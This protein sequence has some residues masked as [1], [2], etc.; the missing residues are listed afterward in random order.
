MTLFIKNRE[1]LVATTL[2]SIFVFSFNFAG[3]YS[4][5]DPADSFDNPAKSFLNQ[6][7]LQFSPIDVTK[8]VKGD[9]SWLTFRDLLNVETFSLNDI[10]SSIKAVLTLFIRL[11]ITTLNATLGISK[12]LLDVL[13]SQF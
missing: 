13:T 7:P 3:A 9:P 12:V 11:M 10:G 2:I 5:G 8:F 6:N 1:F 4:L